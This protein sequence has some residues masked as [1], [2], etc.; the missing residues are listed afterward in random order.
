[1]AAYGL[2][3]TA[4]ANIQNAF[5]THPKI[6]QAILYGSRAKGSFRSN[7][8]IDLTLIGN[9]LTFSDLAHIK[10]EL[11]DLMLPY[12][13]DLSLHHDIDNPALLE[14]I[15]RVGITLYSR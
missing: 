7:S 8:D 12:S 4:I 6:D 3:E 1:M 11:D 9:Q 5:K 13:I 15:E 14:H 2:S 10:N